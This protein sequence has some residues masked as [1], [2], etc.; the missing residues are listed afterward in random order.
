M[1]SVG[2]GW[3]NEQFVIPGEESVRGQRRPRHAA[4]RLENREQF[5][6][7]LSPATIGA[8]FRQ[9]RGIELEVGI[10]DG[11]DRPARAAVQAG[12]AFLA[13]VPL[14]LEEFETRRSMTARTVRI[15]L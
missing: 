5:T 1:F 13:V 6:T 8:K 3:A 2:Q 14:R 9:L 15:S 10:L 4:A 12:R 11:D 7:F